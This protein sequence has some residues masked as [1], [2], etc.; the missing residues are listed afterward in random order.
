LFISGGQTAVGEFDRTRVPTAQ[1]IESH[2]V[3]E[4]ADVAGP[5]SVELLP[6]INPKLIEELIRFDFPTDNTGFSD[7]LLQPK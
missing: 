5:L 6:V 3:F 1:P 7:V 2:F 4:G